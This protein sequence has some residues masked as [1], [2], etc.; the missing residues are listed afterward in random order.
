MKIL[1]IN[2]RYFVSGG[3]ERYMFNLIDLLKSKGHQIIP[4]SINYSKNSYSEY[5]DFFVSPLSNEEEVYFKEQT[6]SVRSFARTISRA[7]YSNEVYDKL[8]SLIKYTKPDFAIVL[9]YLRKLSPS[10]IVALSD[11]KLPFIVR[12]SDFAMICS[13]AHLTRN[14]KICELCIKGSSFNSVKYKCVQN[15]FGASTVNYFSTKFHYFKGYYSKISTF[16]V[17]SRFTIN[18]MIE[19]GWP[20][21]KFTYLPTFVQDINPIPTIKKRQF[22]FNHR[23][24]KLKGAHILLE[25]I[26]ILK[27]SNI[28]N[29][30]CIIA[31]DGP[32]EYINELKSFV[33]KNELNNI[34]FTGNLNNDKLNELVLESLFTV[35]PSMWYDNLP[36]STLESMA[37]GTP[38]IASNKG[39]FSEIIID[40]E[41]GLLFE[42]GNPEQLAVKIRTLLD[43]ENLCSIMSKKAKQHI[44]KNHSRE[45]HYNKLIEIFQRIKEML[46]NNL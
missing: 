18:K 25:A 34:L 11:N 7:F 5:K 31:G 29:F 39:S 10:I 32:I 4:F 40:N 45:I 19:A 15:S 12:I 37:L 35:A 41:T 36:N 28:N 46:S 14:G 38:V 13:N 22:V 27:K 21:D 33:K 20:K 1:L 3:P 43:D 17:P 9:H 26:N 2:Y 8:N 23:L 6:W 30:E 44:I 16:A 24:V 42:M